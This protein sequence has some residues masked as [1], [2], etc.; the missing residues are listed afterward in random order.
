MKPYMLLLRFHVV[1][2]L[3]FC[4]QISDQKERHTECVFLFQF[5]SVLALGLGRQRKKIVEKKC[6][7]SWRR[8]ESYWSVGEALRKTKTKTTIVIM[9]T[10]PPKF[11]VFTNLRSNGSLLL[12][13]FLSCFIWMMIQLC[14]SSCIKSLNELGLYQFQTF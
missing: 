12:S 13:L 7:R 5:Q 8:E 10:T 6:R 4:N 14:A 9:I 3:C 2:T 11:A 1:M